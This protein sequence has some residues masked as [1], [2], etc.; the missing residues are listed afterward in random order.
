MQ[1]QNQ[2]VLSPHPQ[3]EAAG[4]Q[5]L[6]LDPTMALWLR[7][8]P[9]AAFDALLDR[10][11][12]Q[13]DAPISAEARANRRLCGRWLAVQRL[14]L[15]ISS[16]VVAE[17]AGVD[18]STLHLLE[19]GLADETQ[20][21]DSSR[22][23]ISYLLTGAEH[24]QGWVLDVLS[25]AL[26]CA[27]V[28]EAQVLQQVAADLQGLG[29]AP[30]A[31][32]QQDDGYELFRRAIEGR[33]ADAWAEI[34]TRYRSLLIA[35][36]QRCSA[37]AHTGENPAD[38]ADQALARAW[39]ALS[40]ARFAQFPSLAALLAYLRA[41]VSTVVI[42]L[43]RAQ[44]GREPTQPVSQS[45]V[46]ASPEQIVLVALDHA[47][48]WRAVAVQTANLAE[49]VILIE[50]FIYNLQP[51]AIQARHPNIFVDVAA[52]YTAKRNLLTRLQRSSELLQLRR[53]WQGRP[54]R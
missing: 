9:T 36:V 43:A 14:R 21:P 41:C 54:I 18:E 52:V 39:A 3:P 17:R 37:A 47:T 19:S 20:V 46:L 24:D 53:E 31:L 40:P 25:I 28:R 27:H 29:T 51:R 48:L 1:Q 50:S 49:R 32:G 13:A 45:A 4:D 22:E 44:T 2:R 16:G 23:Q 10:A 12:P 34:H 6:S 5:S 35:W 26:G 33:D 42:D 11:D 30:A 7:Q 38:L 15:G 8:A